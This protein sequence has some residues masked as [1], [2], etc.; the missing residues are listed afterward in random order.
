MQSIL[1]N[2][3]SA[4]HIC[5]QII[6]LLKWYVLV[7]CGY[8]NNKQLSIRIIIKS[9]GIIVIKNEE[10]RVVIYTCR[11]SGGMIQSSWTELGNKC[12]ALGYKQ[13]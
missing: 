10:T 8:K 5:T 4:I 9:I 7:H 3:L 11:C 1:A 2:E 13:V 12:P 6:F